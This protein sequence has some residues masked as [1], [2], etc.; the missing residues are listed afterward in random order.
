MAPGP[1]SYRI[2]TPLHDARARRLTGTLPARFFFRRLAVAASF[3]ACGALLIFSGDNRLDVA[4]GIVCEAL[5]ALMARE[6]LK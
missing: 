5:A 4:L 3:T 6:A 1:N 2:R